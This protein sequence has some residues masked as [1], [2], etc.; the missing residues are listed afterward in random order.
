MS[1]NKNLALYRDF[2]NFFTQKRNSTTQRLKIRKNVC[3][4]VLP[5]PNCMTELDF[6]K[7]VKILAIYIYREN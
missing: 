4:T 5:V 6:E 7:K 1:R 2:L 3:R